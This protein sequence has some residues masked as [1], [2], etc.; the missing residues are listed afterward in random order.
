MRASLTWG[1]TACKGKE[2]VRVHILSEKLHVELNMN[3]GSRR[4]SELKMSTKYEWKK[5]NVENNPGQ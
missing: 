5:M 4:G 1:K 2:K 3:K